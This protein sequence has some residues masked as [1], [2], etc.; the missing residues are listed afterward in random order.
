[1][2]TIDERV[3]QSL[4]EQARTLLQN[5]IVQN[6]AG[7]KTKAFALVGLVNFNLDTAAA[8]DAFSELLSVASTSACPP[9]I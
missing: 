8:G 7:L 6:D 1:M 4:R 5:P 2:N 9:R 3:Y